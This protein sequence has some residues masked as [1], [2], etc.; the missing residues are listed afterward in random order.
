MVTLGLCA[1]GCMGMSVT[2]WDG[3]P[4]SHQVRQVGKS[5]CGA[6]WEASKERCEW[7]TDE[8]AAL[9]GGVWAEDTC[10]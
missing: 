7:E 4:W 5:T 10:L 6:T 9:R 3:K 2:H 1:S 8:R